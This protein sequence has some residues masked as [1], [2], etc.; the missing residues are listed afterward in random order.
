MW[1]LPPGSLTRLSILILSPGKNTE[2]QP[3]AQLLAPLEPHSYLIPAPRNVCVHCIH[4]DPW[5]WIHNPLCSCSTQA[6]VTTWK[7]PN[8]GQ[9]VTGHCIPLYGEHSRKLDKRQTSNSHWAL[10]K[11]HSLQLA[12]FNA[13]LQMGFWVES[14]K[15]TELT[16]FWSHQPVHKGQAVKVSHSLAV[17]GS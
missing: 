15:I 4:W 7:W 6:F 14:T 8:T 10:G 12:N 5:C 16:V 1:H 3:H 11:Q 13:S 9:R 2:S 17:W